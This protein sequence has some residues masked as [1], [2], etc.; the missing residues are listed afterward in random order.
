MNCPRWH[1]HFWKRAAVLIL[2]VTS[3][4][5]SA[6]ERT[7]PRFG[8]APEDLTVSNFLFAGWD[9]PWLRRSRGLGT[10]NMS[11][12]RVQTNFLGQLSRT[13]YAHQVNLSEAQ[14]RSTDTLGE[15]VEYAFNRRLMLA[16]V[17]NYRWINERAGDDPEGATGAAFAR[18]QWVDTATHSLAMTLRAGLPYRDLGEKNTTLSLAVAG[19]QDLAPL[20]LKRVGLYYHLQ[21]ET[22]AGPVKAGH[23]RHDL[24]Y[25]ISLAKTWTSPDSFF[26]NAST[27]I[28]AYAKTDLDGDDRGHTLIT[29]TPGIRATFLHRHI[30]MGGVEFPVTTPRPYERIVRLTYIYNF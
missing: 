22:L 24:T 18:L 16:V 10:P 7:A 12:L 3:L 29:L 25:A 21:E 28:E 4:D 13:D 15:I 19:W 1:R 8:S 14:V 27:F 23:R 5:A 17:G 6:G 2:V 26:G 30:L 20:G 9:E 11:L